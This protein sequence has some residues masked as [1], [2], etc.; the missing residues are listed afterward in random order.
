ME[1]YCL[2]VGLRL[3]RAGCSLLT[4][5]YRRQYG[6]CQCGSADRCSYNSNIIAAVCL[7]SLLVENGTVS[8]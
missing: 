1:T 4:R 8:D 7:D 5:I 2:L 3:A 6:R